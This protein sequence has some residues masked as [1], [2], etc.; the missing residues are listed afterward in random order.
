MLARRYH[1]GT[2]VAR[3]DCP[4][5]ILSVDI[6]ISNV[7]ELRRGEDLLIFGSGIGDLPRYRARSTAE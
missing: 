3:R 2:T 6:E 5:K 1:A 7:F 4:V